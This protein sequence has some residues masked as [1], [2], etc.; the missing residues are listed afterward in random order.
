MNAL[1]VDISETREEARALR[2]RVGTVAQ[3]TAQTMPEV[4]ACHKDAIIWEGRSGFSE[5]HKELAAAYR[6]LAD[7][8]DRWYAARQAELAASDEAQEKERAIADVDY[9][10]REL[11]SSLA[12]FDKTMEEKRQGCHRTI[13][14]LGRRADQL[15]G[16]LLHLATRFCAPLRAKPELGQLFLELE[17]DAAA[18]ASA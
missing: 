16:E 14:D 3:A 12:G 7:A 6:K 13:V 10:I 9:Q 2:L 17:R 1:S 11:R 8:V 18:P 15:E 5:P 4:L